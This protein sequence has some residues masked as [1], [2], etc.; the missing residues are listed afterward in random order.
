ME[1]DGQA[2]ELLLR[3]TRS[4]HEA[5]GYP[6][7]ELEPRI[8]ELSHALGL[9]SVQ[10]SSTPTIVQLTVGAFPDQQVFVLR[11]HP[12]PVDLYAIGRLDRLAAAV[13]AGRLDR[14]GALAELD[15][16][17]RHP[18]ARPRWVVAA[19]CGIVA[20]A[21]APILGGGWHE[22]V[23][24]GAVGLAV[25][26]LTR[27][28]LRGDRAA[29]MVTPLGAFLASFL[30]SALAH[31]GFTIAVANVTFAALVVLLPGMAMAI[32]MRELAT[33]HL[34][35]GLSNSADALVK[36]VGLAFG[37][38]LGRSVATTWLGPAPTA[39]PDG[40]PAGVDVVA[41]AVVGLGFVVT[42]RA[43]A[44]DAVWSCSAAVLAIVANRVATEALGD[45]AGVVV[46]S[47][48][49]GLAGN[50][51]AR[52]FHHS[53]LA[54]I[55]P[56][57]LMLVPGSVG[58]ESASSLLAGRTLTGIDTAFDAFVAML[59]I[60]YGLVASTIILP[61]QP[62]AQRLARSRPRAA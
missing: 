19:A 27:V 31:A 22:S 1:T 7:N 11:V 53:P 29:A 55:V 8:V 5:G 28:V 54:F 52:R 10:V 57:L 33:G 18:V 37:V 6:A 3:F 46:A 16:L 41:A 60:S 39:V 45:I 34:Q 59:A 61:D 23:G 58:Y 62:A 12:R 47:L 56:G 38:A 35:A 2:V 24:A 15:D 42:L 30:A 50:A 9:P 40:F 49:V 48:V 21:L 43:P 4:A 44:R 14:R 51:V 32:G 20:A 36:L 25:G 13:A 17:G 26:V